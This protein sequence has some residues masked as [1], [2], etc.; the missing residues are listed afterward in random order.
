LRECKS[1]VSADKN[2]SAICAVF[3]QS[4]SGMGLL[5]L[6]R[7]NHRA[8]TN[9]DLRFVEAVVQACAPSISQFEKRLERER[10]Q[11]TRTASALAR[12]LTFK[13][14][15]FQEQARKV[16]DL[17]VV[18]AE[19]LGLCAKEQTTLRVAAALYDIGMIAVADDIV[20]KT[21]PLSSQQLSELRSHVLKGVEILESAPG[22]TPIISIARS[23]HE[24]WDGTGYPDKLNTEQIPLLARIV[25]LADAFAALISDRPYRRSR[26]VDEAYA[27][28]QSESGRQFDPACVDALARQRARVEE[29]LRFVDD[30]T[31]TLSPKA[32]KAIL[33]AL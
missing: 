27:I 33:S 32:L 3:R 13:G 29:A 30:P 7:P 14:E 20:S 2:Q 19:G 8:F 28:V 31:A 10:K 25:T 5:Y 22:L 21:S 1:F 17:S 11:S 15:R 9:K 23:H 24:R 16:S 26:S 4:E 12:A 6:A 18:L